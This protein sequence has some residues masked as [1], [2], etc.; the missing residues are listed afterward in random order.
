MN[1][2]GASAKGSGG[3]SSPPGRSGGP[4]AS[5]SSCFSSGSPAP[6]WRFS[7]KCSRM[8]SSKIP[9]VKILRGNLKPMRLS[10]R[11]R[12]HWDDR[13]TRARGAIAQLAERLD[14]TTSVSDL[15]APAPLSKK[16]PLCRGFSLP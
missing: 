13:P 4:N 15:T 11:V 2:V 1:S 12:G 16:A 9:M 14:R 6:C 3:L 5:S 10:L 8:A 7:S